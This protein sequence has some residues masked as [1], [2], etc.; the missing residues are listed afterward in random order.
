MNCTTHN[1]GL[2]RRGKTDRNV[3]LIAASPHMHTRPHEESCHQLGESSTH[4]CASVLGLCEFGSCCHPCG[5][6]KVKKSTST[7]RG[8]F[9]VALRGDCVQHAA[10]SIY[11]TIL[12]ST[13]LLRWEV[14]LLLCCAII[15]LQGRPLPY[16][17]PQHALSMMDLRH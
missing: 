16:P 17:H 4:L 7:A 13:P 8:S 2:K 12:L 14:R 5:G 6:M 15:T 10:A 1:G 9:S 11:W 3:L